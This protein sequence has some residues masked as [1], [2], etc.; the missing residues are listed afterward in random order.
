ML[1]VS[2]HIKVILLTISLFLFTGCVGNI[3]L[4]P[5]YL[6]Q[7][8]HGKVASAQPKIK[9][10]RFIDARDTGVE[11]IIVGSRE[12][13]FSTPMGDVRSDRPIFTI[14]KEAVKAEL[15]DR[16]YVVGDYSDGVSVGGKVKRFWVGTNATPLYWDI[17]SEIEI[18]V[19]IQSPKQKLVKEF[20]PYYAKKTERT[21]IWPSEEI[22]NRTLE[23]SL[24]E[25]MVKIGSD[26]KLCKTIRT[27]SKK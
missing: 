22:M 4:S 15:V 14:V 9:L 17:V 6:P 16:G 19:K 2:M 23:N 25:V 24:S 21:Y 8:T 1:G 27:L 13:A 3:T 12:A 11:S 5:N 7:P 20:G 10:S 18:M 26:K